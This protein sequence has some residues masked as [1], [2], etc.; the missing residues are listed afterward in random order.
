VIV[1][2]LVLA[3]LTAVLAA[4]PATAAA[5]RGFQKSFDYDTRAPLSPT[6]TFQPDMET[7]TVRVQ[8]VSYLGA[9][10]ERVPALLSIPKKGKGRR[11]CVFEGHG[12]TLT[13]EEGF[14][15]NAERYG[16][17]GAA[18]FAIDARFHGE[19]PNAIGGEAAAAKLQTTYDLY[20]LTVID[21]RRGLDYLGQR[22]LCSRIGFEGYSMGG[23]MGSM[24]IG[25]DTRVKAG[26]FYVSGA[27][28]RKLFSTS[29]V[30]FG[31]RITGK[32]LDAAVKKMAPIDPLYWIPRAK[33][34]AVFMAAG[35]LDERT[36]LASAQALHRAAKQ[37]KQVIVYNGGHDIEEPF[38]TRVFGA[39]FK[40]LA[41]YLRFS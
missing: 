26:A 6:A 39:S 25:A 15:D 16:A 35:K 9:G 10:G 31:G 34:R 4:A 8:K 30:Y 23:F 20:R 22:G 13:K 33:G 27:D 12:L 18:V 38:R 17:R 19:R 2:S 11:P 40:F 37:P 32:R 28:W 3:M 24:L 7:E 21:M 5:P 14:G 29:D 36:P 41:K 1:R